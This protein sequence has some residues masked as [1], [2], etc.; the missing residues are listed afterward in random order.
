MEGRAV[1]LPLRRQP[2]RQRVLAQL[3]PGAGG[4]GSPDGSA[5]ALF[6]KAQGYALIGSTEKSLQTYQQPDPGSHPE[7][8][9]KRPILEGLSALDAWAKILKEHNDFRQDDLIAEE[10]YEIELD[11]LDVLNRALP[12]NEMKA[13]LGAASLVGAGGLQN[14][15]GL[16]AAL[17]PT[18]LPALALTQGPFDRME[19]DQKTPWISELVKRRVMDRRRTYQPRKKDTVESGSAPAAKPVQ[20]PGP[21]PAGSVPGKS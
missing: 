18:D 2:P 3:Q 11:Y 12:G 15:A 4:A 7:D 8:A 21:P 13:Q 17:Y 19:D 16:L 6:Y 20:P 5:R 14:A 10:S 9:N 1:R